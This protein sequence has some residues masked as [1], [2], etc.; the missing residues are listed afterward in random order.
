MASSGDMVIESFGPAQ[1][2]I[3]EADMDE[4][5]EEEEEDGE[6]EE[7]EEEMEE[8]DGNEEVSKKFSITI[9]VI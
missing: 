9:T 7:T 2:I 1:A 8:D 4:E 5:E 6:M 3:D